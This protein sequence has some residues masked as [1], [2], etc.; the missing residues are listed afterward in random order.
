MNVAVLESVLEG[1]PLPARRDEI[2]DYAEIEG[3]DDDL[4][5]PLR[6]LEDREY[7]SVAEIHGALEA[8]EA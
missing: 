2:V 3:A 5:T 7:E 6:A 1:M 8:V 4:L